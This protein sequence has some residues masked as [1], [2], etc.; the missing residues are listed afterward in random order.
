M[1]SLCFAIA[2]SLTL[3]GIA[4]AQST[5]LNRIGGYNSGLGEGSIEI[6]A[7]DPAS[8]RVASVN[9]ADSSFDLIDLSN[10]SAPAL[11]Q[12]VSTAALG[13]PNSVAISN[14]VLAV[15][16]QDAN[17]QNNGRVAFYSTSGTLLGSV[18][19]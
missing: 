16:L 13:S 14:G 19:V 18:A 11:L 8:R 4:L 2:A 5:T 9:G 7:Y 10:P 12:R 17:P 15:A 1:R 6:S 3:P